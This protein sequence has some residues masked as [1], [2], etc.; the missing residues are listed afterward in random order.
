M[1]CSSFTLFL[2][3]VLCSSA[4]FA[5]TPVAEPTLPADIG[6]WNKYS[7]DLCD[8][9]AGKAL[10]ITEYAKSDD[11]FR[12]TIKIITLSG[13]KIFQLEAFDVLRQGDG[14]P[15]PEIVAYVKNTPGGNWLEYGEDEF[16]EASARF[17]AE[18]GLT[19]AEL[20]SCD[21]RR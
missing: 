16:N 9:H 15:V 13:K 7:E 18:T 6:A 14:Y 12:H 8:K 5:A 11:I 21:L 10:S 3:T 1:K 2:A 17:V 19:E 4:I 20:A